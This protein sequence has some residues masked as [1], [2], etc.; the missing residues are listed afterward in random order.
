MSVPKMGGEHHKRPLIVS[1]E[2]NERDLRG[3]SEAM[4]LVL[5]EITLD[6]RQCLF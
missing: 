5:L 4:C 3:Q 1:R 6:L 2:H